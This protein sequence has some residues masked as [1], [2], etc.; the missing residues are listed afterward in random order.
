MALIAV[1]PQMMGAALPALR[2]LGPDTLLLT[3]AAGTTIAAYEAALGAG[4]PVV[5]AMPNTPAAIGRGISALYANDATVG[6][7]ETVVM[8]GLSSSAVTVTRDFNN[9]YITITATSTTCRWQDSWINLIDTPGHVDFAYEVSRS[10]QAVEGSLLVVDASQGVEAQTLANV[11]QAIDA[12]HEIVPVLNKI[13]L[14]A[15]DVDRVSDHRGHRLARLDEVVDVLELARSVGVAVGDV[16]GCDLTRGSCLRLDGAD[17]LLAPAVALHGVRDT[18]GV[19]V[20][21]GHDGGGTQAGGGES[22]RGARGEQ[23]GVLAI[24]V[25]PCPPHMKV[26]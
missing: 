16:E 20:I 10:M 4:R 15:A 13:D 25:T 21:L 8:S 5:R 26:G 14:P 2:G 9:L 12:D 19:S 7:T 3:V 23:L 11:Y 17:H 22:E 18:D 6:N 1:K 24:H